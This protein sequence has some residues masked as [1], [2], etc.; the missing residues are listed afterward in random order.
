MGKPCEWLVS[1][2]QFSFFFLLD[3]MGKP[4]ACRQ[5]MDQGQSFWRL[6]F[7]KFLI[8][9]FASHSVMSCLLLI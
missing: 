9:Q 2:E 6:R 3:E 7:S 4:G 1:N 8:I 5:V